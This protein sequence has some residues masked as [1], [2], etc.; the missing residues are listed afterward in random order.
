MQKEFSVQNMDTR[1]KIVVILGYLIALTLVPAGKW[2]ALGG[3]FVAWLVGVIML[4]VA[5]LPLL[6]R[7]I[8]ALPFLLASLTLLLRPSPPPHVTIT[9]G[10]WMLTVGQQAMVRFLTVLLRAWLGVLGVLLLLQ[11]APVADLF[12]AL[13]HLGVPAALVNILNMTYRYLFL[14]TDEARRMQRARASR[15]A[16]AVGASERPSTVWKARVT[17]GM[18]GALLLRSLAR[19]QRVYYA[20]LA[21]GYRGD[22]IT[23]QPSPVPRRDIFMGGMLIGLFLL[24]SLT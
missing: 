11:T 21:R 13:R 10:P 9:L 22:L 1:V 2:H 6:A 16:R 4:R 24:L 12:V 3:F 19:S 14:L 5:L 18:I 17:G 20:M 23:T 7:S 8:I 15:S